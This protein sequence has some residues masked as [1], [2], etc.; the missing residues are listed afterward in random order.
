MKMASKRL[1]NNREL[2]EQRRKRRKVLKAKRSRRPPSDGDVD[3]PD[4]PAQG[5]ALHQDA[6]SHG[7]RSVRTSL[8]MHSRLGTLDLS[9]GADGTLRTTN[10]GGHHPVRGWE[11][12]VRLEKHLGTSKGS[13][14]GIN[15]WPRHCTVGPFCSHQFDAESR[16]SDPMAGSPPAYNDDGYAMY[17]SDLSTSGAGKVDK[18]LSWEDV[19]G[20]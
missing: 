10:C 15:R 8:V 18:L 2:I 7:K 11:Q 1:G 17:G 13:Y 5:D 3:M 19:V 16:W 9:D 14:L 20:K 6:S 12:P 4:A